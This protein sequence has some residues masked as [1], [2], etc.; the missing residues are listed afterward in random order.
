ML[1]F[2]KFDE[3]FIK[4]M[5]NSLNSL[6]FFLEKSSK[7]AGAKKSLFSNHSKENNW[8]LNTNFLS[9]NFNE[10]DEDIIKL[11][12]NSLKLNFLFDESNCNISL[13][14]IRRINSENL[15]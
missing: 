10:T 3:D 13:K 2:K 6:K 14:T 8:F 4:I 7:L 15:L 12:R 11:M 9:F 1:I 5:R